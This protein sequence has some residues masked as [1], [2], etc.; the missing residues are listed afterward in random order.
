MV[1][2][3]SNSLEAGDVVGKTQIG[4][5]MAPCLDSQLP[6]PPSFPGVLLFTIRLPWA[7]NS[8]AAKHG[9]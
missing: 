6:P 4:V 5:Q 1:E 3:G 9:E 8:M 7:E 2:A